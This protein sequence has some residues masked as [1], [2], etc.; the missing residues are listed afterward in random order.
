MSEPTSENPH[1]VWNTFD[2]EATILDVSS[3]DYFSLNPV[4]TEIWQALHNGQTPE[5]IAAQL[6]QK[7]EVEPATIRTD[8]DDLLSELRQTKLWK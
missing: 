3:G 7:Y 5:E 6:A 4:A 8:I 2:R 1:L